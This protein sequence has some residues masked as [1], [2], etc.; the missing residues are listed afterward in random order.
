[1]KCILCDN[2][3]A[4]SQ[5]LGENCIIS[6][7]KIAATG[8]LP[9][10]LCPKCGSIKIGNRWYHNRDDLPLSSRLL[11]LCSVSDDH[12][13]P[14]LDRESIDLDIEG[15]SVKF[16]VRLSDGYDFRSS[17]IQ[18]E[19]KLSILKNSCP[20][21]NRLTGSYY[22]S[23]IQ[24]R[25]FSRKYS[26]AIDHAVK[27]VNEFLE[28]E[29]LRGKNPFISR[30][31][32]LKE[33]FDL[34]LGSKS[35]GE[36]IAKFIHDRYFSEMVQ[37]KKLAGR[38]E[39]YDLYRYTY[40]LRLLDLPEGSVIMKRG[41]RYILISASSSD[42]TLMN[43]T[44]RRTVHI[45][46]NEFNSNPFEYTGEVLPLKHYIIL[47]RRGGETQLMDPESFREITVQGSF[48]GEEVTGFEIEGGILIPPKN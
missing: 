31:Q 46:Q 44:S 22:E 30:Q 48:S 35:D 8:V 14:E 5:G 42:I 7:T 25:S 12:F 15:Q 37:N 26:D 45:R 10:T 6:R 41:E 1:M 2:E 11:D 19:A 34:Y 4:V 16:I 3:E 47:S 29:K 23:I 38:T 28:T 40:L 36:K 21:C 13:H 32:R 20:A 33:G 27:D 17:P 18:L 9:L 24:I 43:Y 39:G